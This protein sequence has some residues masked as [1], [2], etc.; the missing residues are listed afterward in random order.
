MSVRPLKPNIRACSN[1]SGK[2]VRDRCHKP[3]HK[4]NYTNDNHHCAKF[5]VVFGK[6]L[7]SA[8]LTFFSV[9][10]ASNNPSWS[11]Y[12]PP[13]LP[14]GPADIVEAD[15][16]LE[17]ERL[18][19]EGWKWNRWWREKTPKFRNEAIMK[20]HVTYEDGG[21]ERNYY[22]G[23]RRC[24]ANEFRVEISQICQKP[25]K[26]SNDLGVRVKSKVICWQFRYLVKG[27]INR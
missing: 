2:V 25:A 13:N 10:V 12:T 5:R 24:K 4:E 8:V 27:R 26:K 1:L 17:I 22:F 14:F 23:H 3:Y 11:Q 19:M 20:Q 18:T 21:L 9:W 16:T 7:L 6:M 15:E